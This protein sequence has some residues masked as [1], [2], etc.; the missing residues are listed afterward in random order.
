MEIFDIKEKT[1]IDFQKTQNEK[2][3]YLGEFK[4]NVI[5]ALR[6]EDIDENIQYRFLDLMKK[7]NAKLLKISRELEMKKIK[8]YIE[9]AEKINLNYR[10]VDGIAYTG[11]IGMVIVSDYPI[12]NENKDVIFKN[13]KEIYKEK[14]LSPFYWEAEG[15]KICNFHYKQLKDKFKEKEDKF[16]KMGILDKI[17]GY[18]CPICEKEKIKGDM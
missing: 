8:K 2:N 17:L 4:E 1:K 14:N 16:K 18:K 10:L 12:D 5:S 3:Y 15:K 11:D 6:K 13:E 9:Y 7:E